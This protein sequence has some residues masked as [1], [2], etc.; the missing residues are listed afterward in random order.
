[1]FYAVDIQ[2]GTCRR[3]PSFETRKTREKTYGTIVAAGHYATNDEEVCRLLSRVCKSSKRKTCSERIF[4]G[5]VASQAVAF[6]GRDEI[7]ENLI[8]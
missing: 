8:T 3:R 1:M 2:N 7:N 5:R 4:Q 6:V